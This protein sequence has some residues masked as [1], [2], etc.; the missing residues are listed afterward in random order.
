MVV[1]YG[2][3]AHIVDIFFQ[4]LSFEKFFSSVFLFQQNSL[5]NV[6]EVSLVAMSIK[7]YPG[8]KILLI[9]QDFRRILIRTSCKSLQETYKISC[10]DILPRLF[11]DFTRSN[12]I[13]Q[14]SY[15]DVLS[16]FLP[17]SYKILQDLTWLTK[18][19]VPGMLKSFNDVQQLHYA[20]AFSLST[21]M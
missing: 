1:W 7:R 6:I 16:R 12:K 9:L 5:L 11:Q 17:R 8:S 15:Q 18:S 21:A 14:D 20:V 10:Q 4:L 3:G 19:F 2:T 13:L